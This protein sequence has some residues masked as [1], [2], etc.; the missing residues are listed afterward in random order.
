[1]GQYEW[2]SARN[3]PGSVPSPISLVFGAMNMHLVACEVKKL[4][5]RE[6]ARAGLSCGP[7]SWKSGVRVAKSPT[8]GYH[9]DA[10][11]SSSVLLRLCWQCSE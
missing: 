9:Y 11:G 8:V 6:L 3:S 7:R 1:M 10:L 5:V 2:E 4:T